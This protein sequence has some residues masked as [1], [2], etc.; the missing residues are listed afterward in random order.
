MVKQIE[1]QSHVAQLALCIALGQKIIIREKIKNNLSL[2]S[3]SLQ[4]QYPS[5]LTLSLQEC[6]SAQM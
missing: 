4:S 3:F 5:F 1:I 2:R 6:Q